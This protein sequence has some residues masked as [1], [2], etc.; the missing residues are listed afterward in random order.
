MK[1]IKKWLLMY[2]DVSSITL[3]GEEFEVYHSKYLINSH[4][5]L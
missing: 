2:C 1:R 4:I 5:M 3:E